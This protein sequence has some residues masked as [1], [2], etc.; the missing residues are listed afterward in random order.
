V[1]LTHDQCWDR[2]ARADHAVL[3]TTRADGAI[4]AVPVCYAVAGKV[5]ASPVDRVK[6]KDTTE[7]GR[8]KNLDRKASA[9][10]L[11]ERWSRHDWSR[12][13]WV[14]AHLVRRSGDDVPASLREECEAALRRRYDQYRGVDFA[15]LLVFDVTSVTGWAAKEP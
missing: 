8:L 11:C 12:L 15:E 10:L 5:I 1:R 9:T 2:L 6:P 3:C 4:D 7:L 13:W 14:R